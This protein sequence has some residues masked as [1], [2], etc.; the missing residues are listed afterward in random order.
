LTYF[1]DTFEVQG[2]DKSVPTY[3]DPVNYD[4]VTQ[5]HDALEGE[6]GDEKLVDKVEDQR[7]LLRFVVVLHRHRRHVE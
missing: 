4:P 5:F 3:C 2:E 1:R 7:Q 6:D